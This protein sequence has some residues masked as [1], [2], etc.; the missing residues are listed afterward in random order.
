MTS[1]KQQKN[2]P[3]QDKQPDKKPRFL[4]QEKT[5][6]NGT[7]SDLSVLIYGPSK[8][9]KSTWCSHAENAIFMATEPG[10][11]HLEVFQVPVTTWD[12]FIEVCT[13]IAKGDHTFRTLI[14][15][16]VDN[17]YKACEHHM[18]GKLGIKHP[19]DLDYGK[20]YS[21][22]NNEFHRILNR[23]ALLP[24][25]LIL[26]S[27]SQERTVKTKRGERTRIV[28]TVPEG[29]RKLLV[30]LVDLILFCDLE[31]STAE[32][33]QVSTVRVI[34]TKPHQDYDAGDRTGKLPEVLPLEFGAFAGALQEKPAKHPAQEENDQGGFWDE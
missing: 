25:G 15:D 13:E 2:P 30:G 9:G 31:E 10:L 4:P 22:I 32:D 3:P 34:K 29:C 6:P 18:C 5:K 14:V 28:P 33:G 19:G 16:T 27:H 12:R 26:V 24:Y 20:G 7:I 1:E 21:L 11:N 8:I 23:V 17:L